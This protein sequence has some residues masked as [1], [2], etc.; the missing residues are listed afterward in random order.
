MSI[1]DNQRII[2]KVC[3]LY[4]IERLSQKEISKRL[5]ISRP[6]VSRILAYAK[7]HNIVTIQVKNPHPYEGDLEDEVLRQYQISDVVVFDNSFNGNVDF[8]ASVASHINAYIPENASVGIM[9]GYSIGEV[10]KRIN[11]IDKRGLSFIP[12]IG[13]LGTNGAD[14]HANQI[15]VNFAKKTNGQYFQ[16]NAPAFVQS[17][18]TA[19]GLKKEP[20]ISEILKKAE[21][22]Q[23]S[24]VGITNI[25][26]LINYDTENLLT[27]Q[28]LKELK[29]LGV[30]AACGASYINKDGDIVYS[31]HSNRVIGLPLEKLKNSKTIAVAIGDAKAKAIQATLKSGYIDILLTDRQTA[32]QIV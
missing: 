28:D 13:G 29:F 32:E 9:T 3:K 20:S 15:A 30:V 27:E 2:V 12:M 24:F 6:Q 22:S 8:Y 25:E 26:A 23:V 21:Q 5:L 10:V 11:L 17:A 18:E 4:Y 16:L 14:W 31:K 7:D 1:I 19:D